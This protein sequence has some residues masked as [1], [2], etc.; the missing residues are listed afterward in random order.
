MTLV[1]DAFDLTGHVSMITGGA[2]L[3]G[4]KHAE[5]IAEMGGHPVLLDIDETR[6]Q[7]QAAQVAKAFNTAALPVI[8]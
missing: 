3:L 4:V 6:A 8:I 5:A 7:E 2:G 1:K